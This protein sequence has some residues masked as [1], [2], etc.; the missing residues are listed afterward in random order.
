MAGMI[1]RA[2]PLV[3][4]IMIGIMTIIATPS[5]ANPGPSLPAPVTTTQNPATADADTQAL[6]RILENDTARKKLLA[7]LKS[8]DQ[9]PA[10][11]VSNL[12]NTVYEGILTP[13]VDGIS[14][15]L[16]GISDQLENLFALFS[17]LPR[18]IPWARRTLSDSESL[19]LFGQSLGVMLM[20]A[21]A[22][23]VG[24]GLMRRIVQPLSRHLNDTTPQRNSGRLIRL[25]AR[26][27]LDVLVTVGFGGT[28]FAALSAVVVNPQAKNLSIMLIAIVCVERTARATIQLL[29]SPHKSVWRLNR[30]SDETAV[31]LDI[32]ARRL[33][34]TACYGYF[35]CMVARQIG[36]PASA[37]IALTKLLGL[38]VA[39]M[40]VMLILQ[41]RT[42]IDQWL[43]HGS[44]PAAEKTGRQWLL[45]GWLADL[46]HIIAILYIGALYL[47]W[48]LA[49]KGGFSY[50]L[51][52]TLKTLGILV[53]ARLLNMV[54]TRLIRRGFRVDPEAAAAF[55]LIEKRANR[56][57]PVLISSSTFLIWLAAG[58]AVL[59]AW[60]LNSLGWLKEQEA[61]RALASLLRLTIML[62]TAVVVWE[63][64]GGMIERWMKKL[65]DTHG[66]SI[67][68]AARLRT[69]LPLMRTV[70]TVILAVIIGLIVMSELGINI[71][72]LLAGAGIVGV[73]IGF[74]SQ[75]LVQDIMT[76]LFMLIEDSV[77]VGEVVDLGAHAGLV[78]AINLRT[79]R[80]RDVHGTVHVVPYSEIS[81]IKNLTREFAFAVMD[82]SVSYRE[83]VDHVIA[84]IQK[85]A[86]EMVE[87]QRI[88]ELV[89]APIE[90]FGLDQF[91]D[92][93]VIIK[94]RIKTKAMGQWDV[95]RAFNRLLK[96]NFD[97]ED[98]EIPYPHQTIYFGQARD[99]SAPAAHVMLDTL[100]Q[101]TTKPAA[102]T[103]PV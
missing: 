90:V 69:L 2:Y 82:I 43:R 80:L 33:I 63:L 36:L 27:F 20:M 57:M 78:E 40:V 25:L 50:L 71:A 45:R 84:V 15:S 74:G 34:Y 32:W 75:K 54:L 92:S 28:A 58:F 73:A 51:L 59:S 66:I 56:Y 52:S 96:I 1:R 97:R 12:E 48:A 10:K 19:T 83:D 17:S 81:T 37:F 8:I 42:A 61:R 95:K 4:L 72:P 99:G 98:I 91:A 94:A 103:P 77:V 31:Y 68:R 6:I 30:F 67:Q 47:T 76:G 11:P 62:V 44:N 60:G 89:L 22:G 21:G 88:A 38:L 39:C 18:I 55:P 102:V 9:A 53:V 26:W 101:G 5:S 35:I 3:C 65:Q 64:I 87:D 70:S 79:I 24:A 13:F 86:E 41:N 93:A 100:Q 49:I 16:T 46:W 23:L 14:Q 85:T 7:Q 29:L